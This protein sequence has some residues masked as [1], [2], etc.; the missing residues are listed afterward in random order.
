MPACIVNI[1]RKPIA[2]K[3]GIVLNRAI[4]HMEAHGRQGNVAT[5]F[6]SLRGN[7]GYVTSTIQFE[8]FEAL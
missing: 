7:G 5:S 4:G 6:A 1:A 3:E 2:G 8:S